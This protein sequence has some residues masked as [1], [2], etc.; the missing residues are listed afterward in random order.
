[1]KK[2]MKKNQI[3]NSCA[4][5][6]LRLRYIYLRNPEKNLTTKLGKEFLF[7]I[8]EGILTKF[9]NLSSKKSTKPEILI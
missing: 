6:V 8:Q 9:I 7:G 4:L 5:L 3:W 1:M 2:Q